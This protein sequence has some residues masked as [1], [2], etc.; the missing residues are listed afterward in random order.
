MLKA[1]PKFLKQK[2]KEESKRTEV[3]R[4]NNRTI[5]KATGLSEVQATGLDPQGVVKSDR[6]LPRYFFWPRFPKS[7]SEKPVLG[8]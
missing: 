4:A 8:C 2:R 3:R 6:P 5:L 1:G 7:H